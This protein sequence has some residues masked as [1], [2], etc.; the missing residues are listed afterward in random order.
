MAAGRQDHA[1]VDAESHLTPEI[2]ICR[3]CPERSVF[4]EEGNTDGWIA[5]DHTVEIVR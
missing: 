3:T 4:L 1:E 2:S 5:S